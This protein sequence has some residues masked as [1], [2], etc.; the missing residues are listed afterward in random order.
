[1]RL[2]YDAVIF[3][4]DGTLTESE[5]GITKS[6]QY[7]LDTL[8]YS[9]TQDLL[10]SFIGP[11]LYESYVQTMGM[12]EKTANEGVRLYRERFSK[13][14]WTENS[15]YLGI[16][17]LL[18][19][20]KAHGAFLAIATSK[21]EQFSRR[22]LQH[23][24]LL[25][26]FDRV[27]A[28][29]PDCET[30]DKPAL[31]K[32]ALPDRFTR[33]C[34]VGDRKYDIEGAR[35]NGIDGIGALYGYGSREELSIA[36]AHWIADDVPQLTR[37]LLGDCPPVPGLFVSLEGSD[38]SGKSTQM[39]GLT[40]WLRQCGHDVLP[41][42]EPGG[43]PVAE[44]IREVVLDIKAQGMTDL[45]EALLFAAARAQHVHD[46]IRPALDQGKT[47]LCDRYVDSSIAYQGVG[48]DL[49]IDLVW[50]LNAPGV[51]G[52]MPDLTIVFDIDPREAI[53]RRKRSDEP[54]RI[55]VAALEF[56]KKTCDYYHQLTGKESG[57]AK[58]FD[59]NGTPDQVQQNLRAFITPFL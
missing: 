14:G 45:T 50:S 9:Y 51:A 34:M 44:R 30:S 26:Y 38:G 6:V 52:T 57:R 17:R 29:H 10:R 7:S 42:R 48:R 40:E 11:P 31:V 37:L 20:L 8:G 16:P 3:D 23:F 39:A 25:Q 43:C 53:A 41:T 12:D 13:I 2:P 15:V 46:V 55:E 19:S 47:V 49:G 5:P 33:A 58:R 32:R 18:R 56:F 35:A 22:I 27:I 24:G 21:P 4:L 36:G 59:A 1:M 28:A 54:D